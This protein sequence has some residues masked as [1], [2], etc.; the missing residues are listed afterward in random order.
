MFL[1]FSQIVLCA[2]ARVMRYLC[3]DSAFCM[4]FQI[5]ST[6][7]GELWVKAHCRV[8]SAT[9]QLGRPDGIC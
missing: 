5:L 8:L 3:K 9:L 4:R 6:K 1:F 2:S 7:K